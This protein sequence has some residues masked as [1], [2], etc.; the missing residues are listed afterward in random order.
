MST[1]RGRASRVIKNSSLE[2][3]FLGNTAKGWEVIISMRPPGIP[4]AQLATLKAAEARVAAESAKGVKVIFTALPS[5]GKT[6]FSWTYA[7]PLN[8]GQLVG[9]ADNIKTTGY[10][11]AMGRGATTFGTAASHVPALERL[12]SLDMAA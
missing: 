11:A 12:P 7:E 9:V 4:A 6:A 1:P 3:I 5:I 8:G 10:G 2:C